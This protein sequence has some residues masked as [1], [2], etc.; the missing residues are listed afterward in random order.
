M[1]FE[2]WM[3]F[4]NVVVVHSRIDSSKFSG[5]R[6]RDQ[7]PTMIKLDVGKGRDQVFEVQLLLL[8]VQVLDTG[9]S[10]QGLYR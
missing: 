3:S 10:L 7:A 4:S 6:P 1:A 2:K 9:L 5:R 8:D